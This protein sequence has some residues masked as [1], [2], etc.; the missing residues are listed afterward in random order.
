MKYTRLCS[1]NTYRKSY[2][3]IFSPSLKGCGSIN[4]HVLINRTTFIIYTCAR[5]IY[6]YA[7]EAE[8]LFALRLWCP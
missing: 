3:L 4:W 8:M 1:K 6:V 5:E 2:Q 7:R